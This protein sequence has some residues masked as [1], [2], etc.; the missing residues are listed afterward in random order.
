MKTTSPNAQAAAQALIDRGMRLVRLKPGTKVPVSKAWQNAEPRASDFGPHD[1]IGVQ[2]GAR[3]GGLVDLDF[4]NPFARALSGLNCF[5]NHAPAFR[6]KSLA[7][8]EPG[9]RLVF[10]PDAPNKVE[11][12]GFTRKLEL[13]AIAPLK[14]AK[15]VILEVRGGAGQTTFPPSILG[16]DRLVWNSDDRE[17]PEMPW[18]ELRRRA[19]LLAFAAFAANCYPPEGRRDIFCLQFAG[20]LIHA[21]VD[22]ETAELIILSVAA[23]CGDEEG[24][25]GK[26]LA[27]LRKVEEG[28]AVTGLPSFLSQ[29]GMEACENRLRSW[30]ELSSSPHTSGSLPAG[31]INVDNPNIAE[32]T[33]LIEDL[34]LKSGV[35]IYRRGTELV[36]V[37][38]LECQQGSRE[39]G[40][41][42]HK[43]LYE[44]TRATPRWIAHKASG[45]GV[46]IRLQRHKHVFVSP[47]LEIMQEL[48]ETIDDR[49]FPEVI[50]LSMTP[51][52]KRNEPGYDPESRLH[53]AFEVGTFPAIEMAPSRAQAEAALERLMVPLRHFPF[54]DGA[55][56]SVAVSAIL[57][58][59]IRG[60][61][62]TCPLYVFDA[63][64]AGTGKTKLAEI[65]GII[66]T[67]VSPSSIAYSRS[68]D[69]NEKRMVSILRAGDPVILIDNV[70]GDLDG[71]LL[72]SALTQEMI[73]ARILGESQT[74]RLSTRA[75]FIAT[76][77][78]LR[79]KGDLT[80][81]TVVC[82]L[83]AKMAN[84]EE[85][86]FEFD[87][88]S[89]VK[90]KRRQ[91][92]TDALTIL[93]A[94]HAA[95]RPGKLAPFGSFE[96]WT[97]V[98]GALVWLG[99][100]DPVDTKAVLKAENPDLEDRLEL[101]SALL[102]TF[103]PGAKFAVRCIGAMSHDLSSP[104]SR[105][106]ALLRDGRWEAKSA[107]WLLSRHKDVP[108][109]GVVLRASSDSARGK[110]YW[111]EGTPDE[112]LRSALGENT[113]L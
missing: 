31:A 49:R 28:S 13:D 72:C 56:R 11:V 69:E 14:M 47:R 17:P 50:G 3:S 108:F 98:R 80:R 7:P 15:S 43:G 33:N 78:N 5:F 45:I 6:R 63:P 24:R 74:I 9:H 59:V 87:P 60:L 22:V 54:V 104:R 68:D 61:L 83:D 103:P 99:F 79:V 1:N 110:T 21:G 105:I 62:R 52:L 81:R 46:F 30:L 76:G 96:D 51:T 106:A 38:V 40:L 29:I 67:D 8:N 39:E 23:L 90:N 34:L 41:W 16:T 20:S 95:G 112:A 70:T 92:V 94:Y 93:R 89:E 64:A 2:L 77:N 44:L 58:A 36:R 86:V 102:A 19:G 91:L 42:R 32:R 65:V 82:R 88:V 27:T 85:R 84:P 37:R 53:L 107:G 35:C 113:P 71:D 26:A 66:A 48:E 73:Q 18:D 75:L 100:S 10:C 109:H 111:I 12:L 55:A 97:F 25:A 101:L 4:D 57:S